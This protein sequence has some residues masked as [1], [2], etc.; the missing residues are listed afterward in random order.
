MKRLKVSD[1]TTSTP[2]F[3]SSIALETYELVEKDS[4]FK[5]QFDSDVEDNVFVLE[6]VL[7][8]EEC[9]A[10]IQR[11]E[12]LGF[13]QST[14]YSAEADNNIVRKDIRDN[15]RV[16][17]MFPALSQAVWK[18]VESNFPEEIGNAH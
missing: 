13:E 10:I 18:L 3:I 4:I 1:A 11:G 2:W 17:E 12:D 6:N 9:D 15:H 8:P 7:T 14:V 16:L 5:V